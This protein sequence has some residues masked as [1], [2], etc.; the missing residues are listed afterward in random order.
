[1]IY[2]TNAFLLERQKTFFHLFQG[3]YSIFQFAQTVG[4]LLLRD[5]YRERLIVVI[6]MQMTTV[7]FHNKAYEAQEQQM[8][9]AFG[10][11]AQEIASFFPSFFTTC[12]PSV[13]WQKNIKKIGGLHGVKTG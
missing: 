3:A 8:A 2:A 4:L 1:M 9:S 11:V 7:F 5:C 10:M 13:Q 12:F 6:D